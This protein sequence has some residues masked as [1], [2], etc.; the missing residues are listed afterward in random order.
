MADGDT[1]KRCNHDC[2][3]DVGEC[4]TCYS[5]DAEESQNNCPICGCQDPD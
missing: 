1:C 5:N 2:H 3:C 4:P